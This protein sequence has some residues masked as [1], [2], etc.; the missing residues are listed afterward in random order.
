[1]N[2]LLQI[3]I[4]QLLEKYFSEYKDYHIYALIILTLIMIVFQILQTIFVSR[5]IER[6]KNELKRS[7][8]KF[9]RFNNLQ[10][11]ALKSIYDNLVT[12]HYKNFRLFFP[13]TYGH[14]SL[15]VKMD[16]WKSEFNSI[17][18][19]FHREKILLPSDLKNKVKDF[20]IKFNVIFMALKNELQSISE[21]EEYDGTEDVQILYGNPEK[22]VESIKSRIER[23]K[24]ITEIEQSEKTIKDLRQNIEDYFESLTK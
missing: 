1:M 10:I 22:E 9:S 15:K 19:I 8:I 7:E 5:K 13:S 21:M 6:F 16:E 14:G 12:F 18:D 4:E 2:I 3:N 17:M 20:E 24:K 11:D 23:L